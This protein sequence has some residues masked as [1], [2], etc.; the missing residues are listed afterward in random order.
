MIVSSRSA[1]MLL[2]AFLAGFVFA[3]PGWLAFWSFLALLAGNR[4]AAW[5]LIP[6]GLG[7]MGE[8]GWATGSLVV[9]WMVA[10][11]G[12][13]R[14]SKTKKKKKARRAAAQVVSATDPV[15]AVP[16]DNAPIVDVH[17]ESA[18]SSTHVSKTNTDSLDTFRS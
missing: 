14:A 11:N 7:L 5:L 4:L 16:Q 9:L 3:A 8:P 12:R 18:P 13:S 2:F 15:V 6:I 10:P 17:L 1:Y